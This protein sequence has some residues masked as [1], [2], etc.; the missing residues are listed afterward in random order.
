M[1]HEASFKE[2][3]SVEDYGIKNATVRYQLTPEEL[4]A[5][6]IEKE[7]AA[8]ASSGALGSKYRRIYWAFTSRP[9][10]S[11]RRHY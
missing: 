1:G 9:I 2:T 6:A 5:I 4:H 8:E 3:I 11:K 10:Y 7:H